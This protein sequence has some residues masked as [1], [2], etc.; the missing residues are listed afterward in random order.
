MAGGVLM[1]GQR[2]DL[3]ISNGKSNRNIFPEDPLE[4]CNLRWS[5]LF[6]GVW[7]SLNENDRRYRKIKLGIIEALKKFG[8]FGDNIFPSELFELNPTDEVLRK[9][10][11][12]NTSPLI[13][14]LRGKKLPWGK[15]DSLIAL[16]DYS[17]IL[18]ELRNFPRRYRTP[19]YPLKYLKNRLP[20]I[21]SQISLKKRNDI[22]DY[23]LKRWISLPKRELTVKLVAYI[24]GLRPE[25]FQKHL[26]IARKKYPD[27]A[28]WVKHGM[29]M[30]KAE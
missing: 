9:V 27:L 21:L 23:I 22:P 7:K 17:S 1:K 24:H 11:A 4:R 19:T 12:F 8:L 16:I 18:F 29:E 6:F 5:N 14:D 20:K 25:S 30:N 13:P 15:Y 28:K 2:Q 10:I 26:T 3:K